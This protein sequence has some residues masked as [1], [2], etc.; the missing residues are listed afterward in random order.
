[1]TYTHLGRTVLTVT[2]GQLSHF[3][4]TADSGVLNAVLA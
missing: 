1:M 4:Q 2:G 3:H